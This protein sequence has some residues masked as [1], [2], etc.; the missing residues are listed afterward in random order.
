MRWLEEVYTADHK[1]L[2][3]DVIV[4]GDGRTEWYVHSA[5]LAYLVPQC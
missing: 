1:E 5:A 3:G 4:F 2:T